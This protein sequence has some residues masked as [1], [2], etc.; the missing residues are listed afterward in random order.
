MMNLIDYLVGNTDRHWGNWGF[1][2]DNDTNR[3]EKLYPLMD[4]NKSFLAYDTLDGARCQTNAKKQSQKDAAL[5]AVQAIGLNQIVQV[6]AEWFDEPEW[7]EMFCFRLT[8][9]KDAA[10]AR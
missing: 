8:L 9:V 4:F 6:K 1:L 3:I 7:W 5:E 2:V 10:K